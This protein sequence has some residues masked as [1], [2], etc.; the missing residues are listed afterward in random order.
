M[1]Y[2]FCPLDFIIIDIQM[3]SPEGKERSLWM[4]LCAWCM[5]HVS[6]W[7]VLAM[8]QSQSGQDMKNS[9]ALFPEWKQRTVSEL[10]TGFETNEG[11]CD[12]SNALV[13]VEFCLWKVRQKRGTS[14]FRIQSLSSFLSI[15]LHLHKFKSLVGGCLTP[16]TL[17]LLYQCTGHPM[18]W[19][20]SHSWLVNFLRLIFLATPSQMYTGV[21]T[22]GDF[23]SI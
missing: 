13:L 10:F 3:G 17:A 7:S 8:T 11:V 18:N 19:S 21:Y 23:K 22:Q 20:C 5:T 1:T 6:S 16:S 9:S 14:D 4:I 12:Y 15:E 2:G